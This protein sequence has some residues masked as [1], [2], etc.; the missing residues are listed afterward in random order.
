MYSNCQV[1]SVPSTLLLL[2]LDA[3]PSCKPMSC[4]ELRLQHQ[5][6][7]QGWMLFGKQS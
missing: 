1:T 7:L 3:Q 2:L 6:Y 5:Q 4:S